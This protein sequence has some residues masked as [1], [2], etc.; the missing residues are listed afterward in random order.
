MQNPTGTYEMKLLSHN[1]LSTYG[2]YRECMDKNV[3]VK[4]CVCNNPEDPKPQTTVE[5]VVGKHSEVTKMQQCLYKVRRSYDDTQNELLVQVFE[6]FN[7]C[8]DQEFSVTFEADDDKSTILSTRTPITV[9]LPPQTAQFI[10]TTRTKGK[11][12]T[13]TL[14]IKWRLE[15]FV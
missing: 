2:H 12:R 10:A 8:R 13:T 5:E 7:V 1:R 9:R 3:D 14:N 15:L 6:V 4:V 11:D